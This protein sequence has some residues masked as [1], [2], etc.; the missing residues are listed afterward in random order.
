MRLL[1]VLETTCQTASI[2][3]L[4]FEGT[5]VASSATLIRGFTLSPGGAVQGRLQRWLCQAISMSLPSLRCA[6]A[7]VGNLQDLCF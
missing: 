4:A 1:G 2:L 3:H 5:P 6:T 7:K